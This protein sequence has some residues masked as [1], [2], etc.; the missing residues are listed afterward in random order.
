MLGSK[1]KRQQREAKAD[2]DEAW[3]GP[4]WEYRVLN[5][6]HVPAGT[7][8]REA[9]DLGKSGWEAIASWRDQLVFKRLLP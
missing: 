3:V 6:G 7:I 1:D 2:R 5:L 4:R 9:D 8:E